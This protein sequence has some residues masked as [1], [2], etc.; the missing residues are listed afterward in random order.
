MFEIQLWYLS[1]VVLNVLRDLVVLAMSAVSVC[2]TQVLPS[3][4]QRTSNKF[5]INMPSCIKG[6]GST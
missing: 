5:L 4:Q 6:Y 3:K 2:L 1:K